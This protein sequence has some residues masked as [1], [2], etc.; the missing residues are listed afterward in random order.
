MGHE[1]ASNK[2]YTSSRTWYC[3]NCNDG[4]LNYNLILSCPICDHQRCEFCRVVKV[5]QPSTH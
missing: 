2:S 5:K 3:H 1:S 4:P